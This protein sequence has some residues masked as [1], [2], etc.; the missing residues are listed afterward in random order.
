MT[1]FR[2]PMPDAVPLQG[3]LQLQI[4]SALWRIDAGTVGEVRASMPPRYRSAHN[5]VQTVLNRLADRGLLERKR[6][7]RA[8][9]YR[10][11]VSEAEY[12][13]R[14][15]QHSLAGAS[16]DARAAALA[17]LVGGLEE[18]ELAELRERAQ[19]LQ[20]RRRRS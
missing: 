13:T 4:M 14:S 8:Y 17:H 2:S 10:P 16:S 7:G 1:Y 9:V 6:D 11:R 20:R 5:T 3:E 12:V 19:E 15:I 18:A